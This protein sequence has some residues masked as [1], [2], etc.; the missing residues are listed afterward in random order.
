VALDSDG[1]FLSADHLAAL[2]T[3]AALGVA[4]PALAR[5]R[6]GVW[7]RHLAR[8]LAVALLAW[9]VAYHVAR[10]RGSYDPATDLPLQLT[11][12]A[13]VVAALALWTAR[14]LPF[15]LTY[16]WA[17]TASLQA[18][19]T[20]GLEPDE[21]FP[22]FFYWHYFVTHSGAIVAALF[23]AFGVGLT[24]RPGATLRMLIATA[25]WASV[26]AVA[27]VLTGG[28]YMYLRERPD[29]ASLLDYMGP[30]P[31]YILAAAL[32]AIALFAL[33]ALPF[34]TRRPHRP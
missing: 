9:E 33:L 16:F 4:L 26:A 27:N 30:W 20:P 22:S 11:D 23:L 25:A 19:L 32:L 12:A 8:A 10:L 28:N 18:V 24:P 15:E 6:P 21:G 2:A 34:R 31:W 5:A 1:L 29:T 13:T 17:L 7:T 3:T 14:P